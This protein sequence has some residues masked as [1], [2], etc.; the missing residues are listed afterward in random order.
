M[1]V[2]EQCNHSFAHHYEHCCP[3][4]VVP[5][6]GCNNVYLPD[7]PVAKMWVHPD[8]D[9]PLWTLYDARDQMMAFDVGSRLVESPVGPIDHKR[10]CWVPDTVLAYTTAV[11]WGSMGEAYYPD[12][13]PRQPGSL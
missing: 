4:C 13:D 10:K 5:W 7:L 3:G 1:P 8:K 12:A 2:C 9:P 11:A 6:C